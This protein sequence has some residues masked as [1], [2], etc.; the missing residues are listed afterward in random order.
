[1]YEAQNVGHFNVTHQ[2]N[3]LMNQ[4][5]A[6]HYPVRSTTQQLPLF[7]ASHDRLS[8]IVQ[9]SVF[10]TINCN[11]TCR[12]CISRYHGCQELF[13]QIPWPKLFPSYRVIFSHPVVI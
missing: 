12:F 5:H 9:F 8:L 10:A 7:R 11:T 3:S 2:N 1:M 4:Y 6:V 13:A